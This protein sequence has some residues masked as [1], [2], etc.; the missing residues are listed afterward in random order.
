MP[1]S[2]PHSDPFTSINE[3]PVIS[4][5]L[6]T[7]DPVEAAKKAK[8]REAEDCVLTD[9]PKKQRTE[10]CGQKCTECGKHFSDTRL[11]EKHSDN[12]K[13]ELL[14]G[15]S[16]YSLCHCCTERF[17]DDG[18][19]SAKKYYPNIKHAAM[20]FYIASQTPH[21]TEY[22]PTLLKLQLIGWV[23]RNT[24]S[25]SPWEILKT[26][27]VKG[28]DHYGSRCIDYDKWWKAKDAK[29]FARYVSKLPT[30]DTYT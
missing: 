17:I 24:L 28:Y 5:S 26:D 29:A 21:V 8:K 22:G 6:P 7:P 20:H 30:L 2:S 13:S 14:R 16:L 15:F 19:N 10:D 3:D 9:I 18:T 25:S 12:T 27:T 23:I 4:P 1:S 11:I